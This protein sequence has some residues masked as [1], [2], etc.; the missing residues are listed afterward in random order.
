MR[1]PAVFLRYFCERPVG[2]RIETGRQTR[3][4]AEERQGANSVQSLV[5]APAL[6]VGTRAQ[7]VRGQSSTSGSMGSGR[8]NAFIRGVLRPITASYALNKK[9]SADC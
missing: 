4:G 2:A 7:G 8:Y 1:A 9:Q 3:E 6:R 5:P